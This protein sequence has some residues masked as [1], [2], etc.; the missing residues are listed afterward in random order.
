MVKEQILDKLLDNFLNNIANSVGDIITEYHWR[1][2]CD[3]IKA[4]EEKIYDPYISR[5]EQVELQ[6]LQLILDDGLIRNRLEKSQYA[7]ILK[8]Y[9]ELID[10]L[11]KKY[12]I[13][14][15]SIK[16]L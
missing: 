13:T 6:N 7:S 11:L 16:I 15:D 2:A 12:E 1:E 8:R 3:L 4:L 10:K 9:G 5:D 14:E